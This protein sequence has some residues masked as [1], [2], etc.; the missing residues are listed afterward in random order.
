[1]A[2]DLDWSL[3]FK[4][5]RNF[6]IAFVATFVFGAVMMSRYR[7]RADLFEPLL[8]GW[9]VLIFLP[10]AGAFAICPCPKCGQF[11]HFKWFR[12]DP[13]TSHCLHCEI[14]AGTR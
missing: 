3:Y 12:W 8:F 6:W 14:K 1:M 2:I 13:I 5:R 9:F 7:D 11:F 10:F 4:R